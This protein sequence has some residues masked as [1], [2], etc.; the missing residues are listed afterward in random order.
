MWMYLGGRVY[1]G[2]PCAQLYDP[3][4]SFSKGLYL[5]EELAV[6]LCD[7][8]S[9]VFGGVTMDGSQFSFAVCQ[10]LMFTQLSL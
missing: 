8:F 1:L 5:R 6:D 4:L 7:C 3:F 2:S 10:G 9:L